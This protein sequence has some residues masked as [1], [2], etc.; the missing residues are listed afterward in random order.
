MVKRKSLRERGKLKL[1]EYFKKIKNGEKVAIKR[2]MSLVGNF[3][4]RIQG[5]TG[6]VMGKRGRSYLVEIKDQNKKKEFIIP[7]IHLKKIKNSK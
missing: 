1:S 5:K 3:P 2:E 4:K 6:T 7:P